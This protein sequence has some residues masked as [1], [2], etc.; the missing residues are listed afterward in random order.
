MQT[1]SGQAVTPAVTNFSVL[2]A[3]TATALATL[4]PISEVEAL[5]GDLVILQFDTSAK[6]KDIATVSGVPK[7][8]VTH[9]LLGSTD[10]MVHAFKVHEALRKKWGVADEAD[11]LLP[12]EVPDAGPAVRLAAGGRGCV[13]CVLRA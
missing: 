6:A 12:F 7:A 8:T 11:L 10:S 9:E 2:G 1:E 4:Y 5:A 3:L 13:Q